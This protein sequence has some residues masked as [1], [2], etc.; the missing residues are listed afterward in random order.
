MIDAGRLDRVENGR[1]ERVSRQD[2]GGL[3]GRSRHSGTVSLTHRLDDIGLSTAARLAWRGR[4][5]YADINGN[6]VLDHPDEY[7]P[8]YAMLNLTITKSFGPADFLAGVHNARD[9]VDPLVVPQQPV[10]TLCEGAG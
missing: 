8:G 9:Y 6:L 7:A 10:R 5:G 2:Y 4:Y 1:D 3:F